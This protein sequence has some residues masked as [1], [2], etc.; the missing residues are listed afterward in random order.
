MAQFLDFLD[1]SLIK[2]EIIISSFYS[3]SYNTCLVLVP[4]EIYITLLKKN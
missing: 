4:D 2:V 1:S 3:T